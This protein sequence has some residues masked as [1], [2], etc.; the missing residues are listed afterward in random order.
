MK[1]ITSAEPLPNHRLRL[2]YSDGV[3]GTVD[4][5]AELGKEV[6]AAWGDAK[7]FASVRIV[8]HGRSL[9]WPGGIDLCADALYLEITGKHV[10]DLFPGWKREAAHA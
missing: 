4:L 10:E 9:E 1:R 3:E 7:H 6:F 8:H 5:S 2:R